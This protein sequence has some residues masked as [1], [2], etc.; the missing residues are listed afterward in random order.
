MKLNIRCVESE[1]FGQNCYVIWNG[2]SK[3]ALVVDPGFDPEAI[4]DCLKSNGLNLAAILCTHGHVDHIAG[5]ADLKK[6]YPDAPIWIGHGDA[7]MLLDARLNLSAKSGFEILSPPADRLLVHAEQFELAGLNFEVRE[8]PGHSPGH[9]VFVLHDHE[10]KL[11]FGGDVLFSGSVGRTDFPGG[12]FDLL[13]SGIHSKLFD[14]PDSTKVFPGHG[15]TTTV[16]EEKRTN[17]FVG[18]GN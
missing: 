11:V 18:L 5:N 4:R 2:D 10:P 3:H 8:V 17:P 12:S 15:P 16:G 1:L 6:H 14:L 7:P 9:I 13:K